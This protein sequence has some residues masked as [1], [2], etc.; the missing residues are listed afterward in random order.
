MTRAIEAEATQLDVHTPQPHDRPAVDTV[1]PRQ[2]HVI[3]STMA[4]KLGRGVQ[5]RLARECSKLDPAFEQALAEEGL[6]E[7]TAAWPAY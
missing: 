1:C 3:Q 5:H 6:S 4:V 7:D 2:S